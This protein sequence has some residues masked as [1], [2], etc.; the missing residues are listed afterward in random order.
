MNAYQQEDVLIVRHG[1]PIALVIG[2][3]GADHEDVFWGSDEN[4]LRTIERRRRSSQTVSHDQARRLLGI[5]KR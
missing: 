5:Q 2:V 3:E 1:Q 4:L